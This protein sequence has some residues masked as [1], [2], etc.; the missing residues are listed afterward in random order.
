MRSA[1]ARSLPSVERA[2]VGPTLVRE[3]EPLEDPVRLP[4]LA[5]GDL[6]LVTCGLEPLDDRPQHQRVRRRGHVHPNAHP[7]GWSPQTVAGE[8]WG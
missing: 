5:G 2:A 7:G 3:P 4:V 6:D 1:S 8:S